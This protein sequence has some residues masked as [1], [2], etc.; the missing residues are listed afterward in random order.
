MAK[1]TQF[2]N[3]LRRVGW[4]Q[5]CYIKLPSRAAVLKLLGPQPTPL[6]GDLSADHQ[7][8]AH[9]DKMGA[10]GCE[11][12]ESRQQVGCRSRVDMGELGG[13]EDAGVAWR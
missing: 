10:G 11:G 1:I 9:D 3:S 2:S 13:R 8:T 6:N 12:M 5:T 4:R 7:P